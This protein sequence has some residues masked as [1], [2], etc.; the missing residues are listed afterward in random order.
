MSERHNA[1]WVAAEVARCTAVWH[2]CAVHPADLEPLYSLRDHESREIAY[3]TVQREVEW[4]ARRLARDSADR[5]SA[6]KRMIA[7]FARFA[8]NALDLEQE[9]IG[10]LT[11]DFLP[12][13]IDFARRAR[14]FDPAISREDTIQACRNAWT[15]CGLQPLLGVPSGI[16]PSILGYSL[17]YP[18]S[19]N[20]LDSAAVPNQAKLT[21]SA[22][23][24]ERLR[25]STALAV[26]P[27]EAALWAL[28]AMIEQ[29]YPR[30][31]FPDV[32]DCLLAIHQAQEDSVAQRDGGSKIDDK[33]ILRLSLAKGGA[34]VLADAGLARGWMTEE[35]SLVA[36]EWGA[37]LQ[38]G[39]DLQDVRDDLHQDS[40]TLFTRAARQGEPLDSLVLQL[41]TFC[42]CVSAHMA[43]LPHGSSRLK[44]L[45]RMSWRSLILG[46]LTEAS[47]FFSPAF[48]IQ[49]EHCSP[50][51]FDF[52]RKRRKRLASRQGLYTT[53]LDLFVMQ[54]DSRATTTP[55]EGDS[56]DSGLEPAVHPSEPMP[57]Y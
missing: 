8:Q 50:F 6:E 15:A 36:F 23:F 21:F 30:A 7:S 35:E 52:L 39:D 2:D 54:D 17:L 13:G 11:D 34:S 53:L 49:A 25:G 24:R 12:V 14:Q 45:L 4:E 37:L 32:Y 51:R 10:L 20:Y 56:P 57:V 18:Y 28:V 48:L 27:R 46:A 19:D 40:Q 47:D 3:D 1:F 33:E 26:N 29:Q 22:R 16:T 9:Q 31:C 41:L 55:G 38:L 44:S 43:G 42:E 5:A